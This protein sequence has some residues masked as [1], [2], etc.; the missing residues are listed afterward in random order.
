MYDCNIFDQPICE[1]QEQET[2]DDQPQGCVNPAT[3]T[4]SSGDLKGT[5][6]CLDHSSR[7]KNDGYDLVDELIDEES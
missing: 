2:I 5:H 6:V 3:S 1:L 7:L 4:V